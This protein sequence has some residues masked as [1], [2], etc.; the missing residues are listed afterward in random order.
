MAPYGLKDGMKNM[1]SAAWESSSLSWNNT[2]TSSASQQNGGAVFLCRWLNPQAQNVVQM[3]NVKRLRENKHVRSSLNMS[4][5]RY[6][7]RIRGGTSTRFAE[8]SPFRASE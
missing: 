7:N 1:E 5:A 2:L 3:R 4:A 6:T 8:I